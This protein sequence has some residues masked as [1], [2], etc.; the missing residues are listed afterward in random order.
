[1][2]IGIDTRDLQIAKTGTKTVLEEISYTLPKITKHKVILFKPIIPV[3]KSRSFLFKIIEHFRYFFWKQIALP[4][5]CVYKKVDV[6]LC[7]D[8]YSPIIKLNYKTAPMF[9]GTNFWEQPENYNKLWLLILNRIAVPAARK[10]DYVLT[11]SEFSKNNIEKY[12]EINRKRIFVLPIAAKKFTHQKEDKSSVRF[13]SL[14]E[15]KYILHVGVMEKRKNLPRLIE[16]YAILKKKS[17]SFPKL[18]LVGQQDPK[19]NS[20]DSNRIFEIIKRNRLEEHVLLT[21]YVSNNE[22]HFFYTHAYAYVFPSVY[23][24]FG[25]PVLESFM[26]GIPLAASNVSAIPEIAKDGALYFDPYSIIS[27]TEAIDKIVNDSILREELRKKGN[28]ISKKY[29]WELTCKKLVD[30]FESNTDD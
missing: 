26:Y 12:L 11:V 24:G 7:T 13:E 2:I 17:D 8:Y 18:V 19:N 20:D 22:L 28:E 5:W 9:H 23:E 30:I 25:I 6:L 4:I 14:V 1:M 15:E 3:F 16:A 10:A 29:S 21:G 27:I